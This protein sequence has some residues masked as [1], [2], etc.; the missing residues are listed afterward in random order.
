MLTKTQTTLAA[1]ALF[2]QP[3]LAQTDPLVAYVVDSSRAAPVVKS[4]DGALW[5]AVGVAPPLGDAVA[6]Q[7]CS[8]VPGQDALA[9]VAMDTSRALTLSTWDGT[10]WT[11]AATINSDC[12]VSTS[13]PFAAQ[14]E[15]AS[16]ELLTVYRKASSTTVYYRS[17]TIGAGAGPELS[18]SLGLDSPPRWMTLVPR[19][20]SDEMVLLVATSAGVYAG[21]WNGSAFANTTTLTAAA[22]AVGRPMDG[23]YTAAGAC[24]VVCGPA[25]GAPQWARWDGTSWT[26]PASL[27][28]G[29]SG[30]RWL[31][32]AAHP[33]SDE[34]IATGIDA[35]NDAA[36]YR[37]SSSTWGAGSII[38]TSMRAPDRQ[39]VHAAYQRDGLTAVVAWQHAGGTGLRYRTWDGSSW[40][41]TSNGPS[42]GSEAQAVHVSAGANTDEVLVAARTPG[43]LV[44]NDYAV[45]SQA[46]SASVGPTVVNGLV[47]GSSTG[48]SLP[49][50]PVGVPGATN[51]SCGNNGTIDISPGNYGS[52]S[53]GQNSTVNFNGAGTYVFTAFASNSNATVMNFDAS[54]GDISVIFTAGDLDVRNTAQIITTGS[55]HV[56][57]HV[58]AGNID[59]GSSAAINSAALYAYN[60]TIT[61]GTGLDASAVLY[62]LNSVT[63]TG[64]TLSMPGWFVGG[65]GELSATPWT[66]GT[67]GSTTWLTTSFPA[68]G[69]WDPLCLHSPASASSIIIVRW[70]EVSEEE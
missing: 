26:A 56:S 31:A 8:A 32:V 11:G 20:S 49:L 10:S 45:L 59:F 70:R 7:E 62:A 67:P 25:T 50:P 57:I 5:S 55:G 22:A 69:S 63:L 13:K 23:A 14:V 48:L 38:E 35:S 43:T 9:L 3:A 41:A 24:V 51:L 53:V 17:T 12:G 52:I 42:L 65:V 47:G 36:T 44:Y 60:G 21:V 29:L 54:A 1:L 2:A 39:L 15:H 37:W 61:F 4:W 64:G 58:L 33:T 16:G 6:W 68:V 34:A 27:S 66:A 28:G 46:G 30:A 40:S 19:R 18:V